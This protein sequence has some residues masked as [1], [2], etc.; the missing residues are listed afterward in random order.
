M[1]RA[2]T[3]HLPHPNHPNPQ[4]VAWEAPHLNSFKLDSSVKNNS[5]AAG[6]IIRDSDGKPIAAQAFN[7]G[8]TNVFVAE[9]FGLHKGIIL[10]LQQG[11]QY[12]QIEGDNLLVVNAVNGIW[13][14]PWQIDHII[15]DIKILFRRFPHWKIRQVYREA[16][17]AADWIANVVHLVTDKLDIYFCTSSALYPILTSDALGSP[18]V[19]RGS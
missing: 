16:N 19:R 10:A 9:A 12:L 18:L 11:I 3:H 5:S 17:R 1:Q 4:L 2:Q 14:T 15:A 8:T 13:S 7:L 6:V